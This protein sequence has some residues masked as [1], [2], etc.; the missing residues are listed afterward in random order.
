MTSAFGATLSRYHGPVQS[1]CGC[2]FGSYG[3]YRFDG[4]R[5]R[6]IDLTPIGLPNE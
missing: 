4:L 5:G 6:S 2:L 3:G 1:F